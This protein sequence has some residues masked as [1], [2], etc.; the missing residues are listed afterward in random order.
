MSLVIKNLNR[1]SCALRA[2][3]L[4]RLLLCFSLFVCLSGCGREN[5]RVT[6]GE[7]SGSGRRSSVDVELKKG[8]FQE[9]D[10]EQ[11]GGDLMMILRDSEN[12]DVAKVNYLDGT[13]GHERLFW[14]AHKD[15]TYR[16]EVKA[17]DDLR[18]TAKYKLILQPPHA[19]TPEDKARIEAQ[20]SYLRV[21]ESMEDEEKAPFYQASLEKWRASGESFLANL[22]LIQLGYAFHRTN[23]EEAA[24]YYD[25]ALKESQATGDLRS[26]AEALS[27]LGAVLSSTSKNEEEKQKAKL[28]LDQALQLSREA[29]DQRVEASTMNNIAFYYRSIGEYQSALNNYDKARAQF[30]RLGKREEKGIALINIG[31][32]CRSLGQKQEAEGAYE[33][34]GEYLT[35]PS[36]RA[37]ILNGQGQVIYLLGDKTLARKQEAEDKF[38]KA[39]DTLGNEVDDESRGFFE[40]N[41]GTVC[42]DLGDTY[43]H[44]GER[45]K[46]RDYFKQASLHL[47]KA[48]TLRKNRKREKSHTLTS[49]GMLSHS[50]GKAQE[51]QRYLDDALEL[52]RGINDKY[53][54][55][56][57]IAALARFARDQGRL[58]EAKTKIEEALDIVKAL[59]LRLALPVLRS[60]YVTAQQHFYDLKADILL[61]LHSQ[62]PSNKYHKVAWQ[63][64]EESRLARRQELLDTLDLSFSQ[65][66]DPKRSE[67]I[68]LTAQLRE[69]QRKISLVR[70][71]KNATDTIAE[72]TARYQQITERIQ[73][74]NPRYGNLLNPTIK[75]ENLDEIQNSLLAENTILLEYFLGEERSYLWA[76]TKTTI[77][78]FNLPNKS[79]IE[80]AALQV[81]QTMTGSDM[82]GSSANK[83][84]ETSG[85]R[86]RRLK[87]LEPQYLS[88]SINLS[89]LLLAPIA[90]RL[91]GKKLLIVADGVLNRIS[92]GALPVPGVTA[93]R[94]KKDK[95][96]LLSECEIAYAPSAMTLLFLTRDRGAKNNPAEST[97][98]IADPVFNIRHELAKQQCKALQ[99]SVSDNP[100]SLD[101]LAAEPTADLS[102]IPF[103][104]TKF[105]EAFFGQSPPG[106]QESLF[107]FRANLSNVTGDKLNHHRN[108]I[109]YT[110][111]VFDEREQD[112]SGLALS[113][114][115]ALDNGRCGS[116]P[117]LLKLRDIYDLK[118]S[119]DLV[120]LIACNTVRNQTMQGFGLSS[121]ASGFM[122]AGAA[123]V[124]GTLWD[125]NDNAS[126]ELM[127]RFYQNRRAGQS[128]PEALRMAQLS[129]VRSDN[130][131][132]RL[133]YFWAGFVLMGEIN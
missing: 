112:L 18:T 6:S 131:E 43:R 39:L 30:E 47:Q 14:I 20:E 111:G 55:A 11:L 67:L 100:K 12:Q 79:Q 40:H 130:P 104:E 80:S 85:E 93:A 109:F 48:L 73:Q 95:R 113:G 3:F 53:H 96:L 99:T 7:I 97:V 128:T 101:V 107:Q 75:A 22:T 133:P 82:D 62:Q 2:S 66:T 103:N 121:I 23:R 132:W 83:K 92:F 35:T 64:V 54:Q 77:E 124:L 88:A 119:A 70:N 110:H 116:Q 63:Q 68:K 36:L 86:I 78:V 46:S 28:L 32:T 129:F 29:G 27:N 15:E 21:R 31:V 38:K 44:L 17:S 94:A 120:T 98:A 49:L 72:L 65:E 90:S 117:S 24:K 74:Q 71:F 4:W 60:T 9:I 61:R 114:L 127:A 33:K 19:P 56:T 89:N 25:Q 118:L 122:Y 1:F 5:A 102:P 84:Q 16:L 42:Y 76:I 37:A 57:I 69:V 50:L 34:A 52:S 13:S 58:L 123:Q 41:L 81:H 87:D 125:I 10:L 91:G 106:R 108:I 115:K 8:Q 105:R 45:K 51:A 126:L 59:E 26:Q